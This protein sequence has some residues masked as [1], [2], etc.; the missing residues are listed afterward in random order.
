MTTLHANSARDTIA[1]LE[2]MLA[3]AGFDVPI[4]VIR[5][6][7]A[8]AIQLVIHLTRLPDGR[9]VMSE[10]VEVSGA[11]A[12]AVH[13]RVL[14]RFDHEQSGPRPA[15]GGFAA[16]GERPAFLARL[17]A[18]GVRL[19]ATVFERGPLGAERSS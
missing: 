16:T 12:D 5:E 6:Y 8:S 17:S 7:V 15:A 4:R 14:H 1:R 3:M 11:D 18:R 10:A 9:R 13:L 19:P 2:M